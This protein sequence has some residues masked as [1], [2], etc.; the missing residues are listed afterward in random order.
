MPAYDYQ[1]AKC[2]VVYE[3][4]EGFDAPSKH[5]CQQCGKGEARRLLGV[6][7]VVFKGSGFY[8]TDNRAAAAS[9]S[10]APAAPAGESSGEIAPSGGGDTPASTGSGDSGHAHGGDSHEH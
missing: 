9:S 4:R 3:L 6:P 1:C 2:G 8:K 5:K 7:A 10:S